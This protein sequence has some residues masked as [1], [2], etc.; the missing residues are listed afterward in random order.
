VVETGTH[1]ALL[2]RHGLYARLVAHQLAG[3]LAAAE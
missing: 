3:S 1:Q 2:A